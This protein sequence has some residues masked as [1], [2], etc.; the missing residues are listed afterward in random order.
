MDNQEK[1]E[2]YESL[3][4]YV[5][6]FDKENTHF[7]TAISEVPNILKKTFPYMD[8]VGFY[9]FDSEKHSLY[10]GPYCG[11]EACEIIPLNKGV[12][13]KCADERKTQKADD[14]RTLSYHI[15][16]SS[17]TLSEIVVPLCIEKKELVGV[18]DIDSDA[19]AAFDDTDVQYLKSIGYLLAKLF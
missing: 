10:L 12:C 13:G 1:K 7:L 5:K 16:C 8:W 19:L 11:K 2:L 14:V 18:L 17:S 3:I 15:A 9:L 6:A 4:R